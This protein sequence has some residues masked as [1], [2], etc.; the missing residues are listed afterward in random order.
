MDVSDFNKNHFKILLYKLSKENK[1]VFFLGDFII[2]LLIYNDHQPTNEFL[3]AL[4]SNSFI[5]Y[6]LQPTRI[7]RQSKTLF[8]NI[9]SNI[10]SNEVIC[11]NITATISGRLPQF[12][13]APKV[14]SKASC[15]SPVF[16]REI[17]QK[18]FRQTLHL[19]TLIKL[20]LRFS[21]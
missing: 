20:G 4:A 10:I 11:G 5:T 15:Q 9:F 14:L 17:G 19:T 8:D 6:I 12:V 21:N 18:S 2:N 1:E 16:M 7:T 3:D 13:F